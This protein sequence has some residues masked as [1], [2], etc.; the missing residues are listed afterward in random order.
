MT[1][2]KVSGPSPSSPSAVSSETKEGTTLVQQGESNLKEVSKRLGVSQQALRSANPQ[3]RGIKVQAG[4]ELKLPSK[5]E[6]AKQD[7][8]PQSSRA[9]SDASNRTA[10]MK[11]TGRYVEATLRNHVETP[12][13]SG[14]ATNASPL[15]G[16]RLGWLKDGSEVKIAR[17]LSPVGGHATRMEAI[18]FARLTGADPAAVVKDREGKWHAVQTDKNFYG[19][20]RA[21]SDNPLHQ[22]EGLAHF[23]KAK[24]AEIQE[25]IDKARAKGDSDE[26]SRL[27][28]SQAALIF[29]VQDSEINFIRNSSDRVA[30]KIN[31]NSGQAGGGMHGAERAPNSNFDPTRKSAMEISLKELGDPNNAPGIIFHENSHAKDYALTQHWVK[32]YE[33][34]TGRKFIPG[35]KGDPAF[36]VWVNKQAPKRISR[37]DAE[38]VSDVSANANGSSE[39]KAYVGTFINALKAGNPDAAAAQLRT[40]AQG[41]LSKPQKINRPTGAHVELELKQQLENEYRK[42]PQEM[43]NQFDKIFKELSAS[44]K[45]QDAWISKFNHSTAMGKF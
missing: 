11:L 3:I 7:S 10:E 32:Q 35:D 17:T 37:A 45:Y 42:M 16:M 13:G 6:S 41:M 8:A 21:S 4:Q 31:I 14:K 23:D 9:S 36:T 18:A 5:S 30:G 28:K 33:T 24:L 22:V 20:F 19:G 27:Q 1:T 25:D 15:N 39:A 26:V 2:T 29:G 40:Y 43:K 44:P 38:L 34:E 12:G